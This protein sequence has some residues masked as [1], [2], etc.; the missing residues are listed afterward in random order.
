MDYKE[1]N[2]AELNN[3]FPETKVKNDQ[4]FRYLYKKIVVR[5]PSNFQLYIRWMHYNDIPK[6]CKLEQQIFPS[7]WQVESFL[8]ELENRN[9]N[10]SLAGLIGE[11]LVA[12]AVSYL[13]SDEIHISNLAVAP[14][15]RRLKIGET[16]LRITLQIGLAK[17][18]RFAHLEV[19]KNNIAAIWLYKK[20]GFRI[21]GIRNNY[22]QTENE[23]AILMSR[24]LDAENIYGVV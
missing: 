1:I 24:K 18:C 4:W 12:Y 9:Y 8:Y 15:Y 19:R 16:M 10:I 7:P 22:Y 3:P 13:V 2:F 21:V 20:Y 23:D 17:K 11:V 5:L 14:E 6:V